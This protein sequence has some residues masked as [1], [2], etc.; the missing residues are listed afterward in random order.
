MLRLPDS[1][2]FTASNYIDVAFHWNFIIMFLS[3]SAP[4]GQGSWTVTWDPVFLVLSR[5]CGM[6]MS[7]FTKRS[8]WPVL[9]VGTA[10]PFKIILCSFL[11]RSQLISLVQ[12]TYIL[13]HSHGAYE[14]YVPRFLSA[15]IICRWSKQ[16]SFR[17][18]WNLWSKMS[19]GL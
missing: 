12:C 6:A 5:C 2:I 14:Y 1:S 10:E 7:S 4:S 9:P 15:W 3:F 19:Q 13:P 16:I 11:S 18:N 17:F 8:V